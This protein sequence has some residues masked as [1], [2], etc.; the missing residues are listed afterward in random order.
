M[1]EIREGW[2]RSV[3]QVRLWPNR[4][5]FRQSPLISKDPL[6][7]QRQLN[8]AHH[9]AIDPRWV[10]S[11]ARHLTKTYQC[12]KVT[13]Y[14]QTHYIPNTEMVRTSVSASP[15][16]AVDFEAADTYSERTKLGVFAWSEF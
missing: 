15:A 9:L 2:A 1:M 16:A 12:Q 4:I 11:Y 14:L 7:Y 3:A 6:R 8:L 13:L 5:E 10:A